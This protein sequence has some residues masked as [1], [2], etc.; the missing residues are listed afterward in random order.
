MTL[1]MKKTTDFRY[2]VNKDGN[3]VLQQF[4][5][6]WHAEYPLNIHGEWVDVENAIDTAPNDE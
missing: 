2:F 4:V 1:N 5:Q 3:T 6:Y